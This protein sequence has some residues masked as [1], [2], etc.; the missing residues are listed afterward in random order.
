MSHTNNE[1]S[2]VKTAVENSLPFYESISEAISLGLA[3][4]LRRRA[5]RRLEHV[6]NDW[7]LDSGSGPGVS[8]R[9]LVDDGFEH[10]IG[11]DPSMI[12]LRS[13]KSR[14]KDQFYP[15]QAVA[16][17]IPLRA[18]SVL[19][20][21]T[22]YSL[23]DVRDREQSIR[24]FAR[25]VKE[26]G[27]LEIVDIGKPDGLFFQMLVGLYVALVMPVVARFLL[28]RRGHD[29]P[30]RMIIPTFHQLPTNRKLT[31][32]TGRL[33][34]A[35]VLHEFLFGGLVIVEAARMPDR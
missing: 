15:V 29:N 17:N 24:E 21:L 11:L 4:P 13:T 31:R 32:V 27:R 9:M 10:V 1:W 14:L 18:Q 12:L 19:G 6:R 25:V 7:V 28:G 30:F 2:A 34:G 20:I 3:G 26:K 16:E 33:F 8:S 22:C 5:I 35:S 23:R